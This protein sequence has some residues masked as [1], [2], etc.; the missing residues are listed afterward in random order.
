MVETLKIEG[1]HCVAC[2][3]MIRKILEE[4]GVVVQSLSFQEGIAVVD[5]GNVSKTVISDLLAKKGYSLLMKND[6]SLTKKKEKMLDQKSFVLEKHILI[7][8][9][10]LLGILI[11]AQTVL[12]FTLYPNAFGYH[13]RYLP[14]L[15]YLPIAIVMNIVALWH[16]RA[17]QG[18]VS[19][20]TGMMIGMT[21]GMTSG[22][23]IG[24]LI[25]LSNGMFI[26]SVVGTIAGIIAGVYGGKCC[27]MMGM[28]EGSMAGLMSGTM[29]AMLTVMLVGNYVLWFIP[30]LFL[31]CTMI[32][33]GL[34][35]V[36][37]DEHEGSTAKIEP[38]P[39][40]VVALVSVTM[41]MV[42]SAI[43]VLLPKGAY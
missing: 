33:A 27:G 3:K 9:L 25:G 7:N 16:H 38:W 15:L 39:F 10:L 14:V 43:V 5:R 31:V 41:L 2:E 35:K 20:M 11:L 37:I 19:C 21:I 28:M 23:M 4:K 32:L 18:S 29:G 13:V 22:F 36:I 30:F 8:G 26:G 6:S 40:W 34:V 12:S 42:L 1:M 17:Y 24:A